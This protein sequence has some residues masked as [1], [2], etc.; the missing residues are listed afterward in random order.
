MKRI[1][2]NVE[3]LKDKHPGAHRHLPSSLRKDCPLTFYFT[4]MGE[5]R[6]TDGDVTYA[7]KKGN[8]LDARKRYAYSWQDVTDNI[9]KK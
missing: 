2:F 9:G 3:S 8:Y 1:G 5:L 4:A 6:G 7:Y